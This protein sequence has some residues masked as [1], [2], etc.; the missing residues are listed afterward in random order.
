MWLL[1]PKTQN[2]RS[3][4]DGFSKTPI[5]Q[6]GWVNMRKEIVCSHIKGGH[7]PVL[8]VAD[9]VGDRGSPTRA[10]ESLIEVEKW[11]LLVHLGAGEHQSVKL[12]VAP[13]DSDVTRC[14]QQKTCLDGSIGII[15]GEKVRGE[16]QSYVGW[17]KSR[18]ER[19]AFIKPFDLETSRRTEFPAIPGI[20]RA[21]PY[22]K[23]I[24]VSGEL[25]CNRVDFMPMLVVERKSSRV[26]RYDQSKEWDASR[27]LLHVQRSWITRRIQVSLA[28]SHL[29]RHA[30]V[31]RQIAEHQAPLWGSNHIRK[32]SLAIQ[33]VVRAPPGADQTNVARQFILPA[34]GKVLEV[35]DLTR[36]GAEKIGLKP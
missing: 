16:Q 7:G 17:R 13:L 6:L 19:C 21:V 11:R 23:P 12:L 20:M 31:E 35:S 30:A 27:P 10:T 33:I 34:N 22:R 28:I 3:S 2:N 25:R 5:I 32:R 26:H 4:D 18:V 36:V 1:L 15:C 24:R 9:F 8:V 29:E 14:V